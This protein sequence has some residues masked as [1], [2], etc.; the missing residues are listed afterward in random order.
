MYVTLGDVLTCTLTYS[1][2]LALECHLR[3]TSRMA[4]GVEFEPTVSCPTLDESRLRHF[5]PRISSVTEGSSLIGS[6]LSR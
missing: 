5:P 6:L 3:M 4:E 2:L 1:L